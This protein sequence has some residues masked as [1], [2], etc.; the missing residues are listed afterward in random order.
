MHRRGVSLFETM[1]LMALIP[2]LIGMVMVLATSIGE[3]QYYEAFKQY[4]HDVVKV[5][6]QL[7]QD[8][9]HH[10]VSLY[11][12]DVLNKSGLL[13]PSDNNSRFHFIGTQKDGPN[14]L[15]LK[16]SFLSNKEHDAK[17]IEENLASRVNN[18]INEYPVH[19]LK[20]IE[21][22]TVDGH[23]ETIL[24]YRINDKEVE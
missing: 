9:P 17:D 12:T 10:D 1:L 11:T 6:Q 24:S 21:Q 16:Y 4:N 5:I 20:F 18:E 13:K 2:V 19:N 23:R 22:L 3:I 8:N 14:H 15:L 7:D